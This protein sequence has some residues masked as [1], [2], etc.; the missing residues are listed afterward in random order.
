MGSL[1]SADTSRNLARFAAF[2]ALVVGVFV[3]AGWS[4]DLETLTNIV[5]GWPRMVRLTA[6]CFILCGASLWLATAGAGRASMALAGIVAPC[7]TAMLI[8]HGSYWNVYI[9]NLSLA[10]VPAAVEGMSPPRMAA[11]TALGFLLLGL[12]L[13]FAVPP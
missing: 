9:D 1:E 5:P 10:P 8:A 3:L 6:L 7:G 13:L 12:S 4:A 11:A 2:V